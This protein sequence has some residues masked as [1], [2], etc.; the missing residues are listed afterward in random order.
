[1]N[2][3]V[4][5]GVPASRWAASVD[6]LWIDFT[7]GLGAPMGAVLAGSAAFIDRAWTFKHRFGGA[8]RQAGMMAAGCLHALDHHVERLAVDHANLARLAEGLVG[9]G[10][11]DLA[12]ATVITATDAQILKASAERRR[13]PSWAE[14][15]QIE[16]TA[17]S[18]GLARGAV[19]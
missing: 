9:L 6:S 8:M 10:L 13:F 14:H 12:A 16:V 15:N 1:M 3:V 5:S 7:K 4:A 2:A 17:R 19:G 11:D 18:V